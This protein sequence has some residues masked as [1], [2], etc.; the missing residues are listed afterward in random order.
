MDAIPA[1]VAGVQSSVMVTPPG[2]DGKIN[3]NILA[4]AKLPAFTKFIKSAVLKWL[5][6]WPMARK[7]LN[8]SIR[9]SVPVIF[10]ATAKE[11]F[12]KVDID[13]TLAPVRC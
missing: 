8:R 2:R 7:P 1:L 6:P 9:L 4:A 11:V 3:P 12:G 10:M 5:P 13:M